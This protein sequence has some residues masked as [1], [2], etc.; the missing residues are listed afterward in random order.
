MADWDADD[1]EPDVSP[2]AGVIASDKWDGEDEDD[3][4]KVSDD[5]D[6]VRNSI[7]S[8]FRMPG[9]LN[10]RRKRRGMWIRLSR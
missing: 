8:I 5:S 7:L 2:A 1:F 6:G 4:V 10:L 3:D 9:M